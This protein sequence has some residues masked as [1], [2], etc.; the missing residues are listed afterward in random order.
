MGVFMAAFAFSEWYWVSLGLL[1]ALGTGASMLNVGVQTK[2]A[3]AGGKRVPGTRD[4]R[5]EHD[6][7]ECAS[8]GRVAVRGRGGSGVPR[9][10]RLRSAGLPCSC[11][12]WGTAGAASSWRALGTSE[13]ARR[14]G[15]VSV[16]GAA[17]PS[18]DEGRPCPRRHGPDARRNA[19]A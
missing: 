13:R 5:V 3:D 4:G 10:S 7:H 17:A 2:P 12:R 6:A 8:D 15:K 19:P 11:S 1:F 18:L 14:Q 9:R 16:G